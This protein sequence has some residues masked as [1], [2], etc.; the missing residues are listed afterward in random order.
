LGKLTPAVQ[1]IPILL[2]LLRVT[3]MAVQNLVPAGLSHLVGRDGM[4]PLVAAGFLASAGLTLS[5]FAFYLS[6]Y[7][8]HREALRRARREAR[9]RARLRREL[10]RALRDP[11]GEDGADDTAE[12][13]DQESPWKGRAE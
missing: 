6:R 11:A 4:L 3:V 9:Q 10:R 8:R 7:P 5:T 1:V 2:A 12:E 13:R